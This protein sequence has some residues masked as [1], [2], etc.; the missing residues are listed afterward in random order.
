MTEIWRLFPKPPPLL[1]R[2][3]FARGW[4]PVMTLAG[5]SGLGTMSMLYAVHWGAGHPPGS[6]PFLRAFALFLLAF[7]L[8]FLAR[9]VMLR[10]AIFNLESLIH[11]WRRAWSR[12][13]A[14]AEWADLERIPAEYFHARLVEDLNSLPDAAFLIVNALT[15][16]VVIA[17]A[18]LY[19]AWF[20]PLGLLATLALLGGIG[21][22]FT[23][24]RGRLQRAWARVRA[25]D[26]SGNVWLLDLLRGFRELK[27]FRRKRDAALAAYGA[28]THDG[29]ATKQRAGFIVSLNAW[30]ESLLMI[31]LLGLVVFI[32]PLLHGH[33][34]LVALKTTTSVLFI[35]VS[36]GHVLKALPVWSKLDAVGE[37]LE[38]LQQDLGP[39]QRPLSTVTPE[40]PALASLRWRMPLPRQ[41]DWDFTLRPGTILLITGGNGSGKSTLLKQLTGLYPLPEGGVFQWNGERIEDFAAFRAQFAGVFAQP[42]VFRQFPCAASDAEIDGWLDTLGLHGVVSRQPGGFHF[43]GLSTGQHKRLALVQA[44]LL[45]RSIL[46]LDEWAAEQDPAMRDWFYTE[47]LPRMTAQGKAV[48]AVTHDEGYFH[49][50]DEVL[51]LE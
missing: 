25:Q 47:F 20:S 44:V 40:W 38:Q 28:H 26:A 48:V 7:G 11:D 51:R 22:L 46:A 6:G 36:L 14:R 2:V 13:I 4:M 50:A 3:L 42:R 10:E 45:D 41:G 19:I 21:A 17:L 5:L 32:L 37:R 9:I 49:H 24:Q 8:F 29:M 15:S 34:T 33:D 12:R 31:L 30:G 1:A 18:L 23:W 16:L 35:T 27:L 39:A 43:D